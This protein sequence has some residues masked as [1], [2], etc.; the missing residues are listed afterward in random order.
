MTKKKTENKKKK[1]KLW[2]LEVN[3][4][5]RYSKGYMDYDYVEQLSDEEKEW[6]AT[7][8]DEYYGN[9]FRKSGKKLHEEDQDTKRAIYRQT[10]ERNRDMYHQRYRMYVD[11]NFF[12]ESTT[13]GVED[14]MV[15][16]LD[17][18]K[19]I[20]KNVKDIN[21]KGNKEDE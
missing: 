10:N 14:S 15:E 11:N 12:N 3:T 8:N 21:D 17:L 4:F 6:L 2:G 13:I 19:D 5:P 16:F 1:K 20:S 9:T 18:K 7:F